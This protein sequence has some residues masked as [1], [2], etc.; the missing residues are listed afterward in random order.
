MIGPTWTY[1]IGTEKVRELRSCLG[2]PDGATVPAGAVFAYAIVPGITRALIDPRLAP[3]RADLRLVSLD[4][5]WVSPLHPNDELDCSIEVDADG[6]ATIEVHREGRRTVE[7]KLRLAGD[8]PEPPAM[9]GAILGERTVM[10]AGRAMAFAAA[11]WDL[12][13]AYWNVELA[14]AAGLG[15]PVA[16]PGLALTWALETVR[17]SSGEPVSSATIGFGRTPRVGEEIAVRIA[18]SEKGADFVVATGH[19]PICWGSCS[20]GSNRL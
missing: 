19:E 9:N 1:E 12:N 6:T 15:G 18:H 2:M 10:D 3:R 17:R 20:T 5:R 13:P 14:R 8:T 11:T 7:A 4:L 16:P